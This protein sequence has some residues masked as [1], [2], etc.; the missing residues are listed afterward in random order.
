[1]P[2]KTTKTKA[3]AEPKEYPRLPIVARVSAG[4]E[5]KNFQHGIGVL[6]TG[7]A[8]NQPRISIGN[9]WFPPMEDD[10]RHPAF[11]RSTSVLSLE[12]AEGFAADILEQVARARRGEFTITQKPAAKK[13]APAMDATVA[14]QV[15]QQVIA[16]FVKMGMTQEQAEAAYAKSKEAPAPG[17]V[18]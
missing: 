1:M 7:N 3:A 16:T 17:E 15:R 12:D 6:A 5:G 4:S 10:T 9:V 2:A 18:I 14:D 8:E 13:E 11:M